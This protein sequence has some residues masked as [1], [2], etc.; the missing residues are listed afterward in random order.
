MTHRIVTT[1][2]SAL[3]VLASFVA[4]SAELGPCRPLGGD[5]MFCGSGDGAM[6]TFYKTTSPSGRLAFGWRLT[7]RPPTVVPEEND[8]NL[9]NIVA[10]IGDGAILAKSHGS[11]W[12]L[13]SKIAKEYAFTAW[14]TDSRLMIKLE[15]RFGFASAE[16]FAFAED[17]TAIGPVELVNVIKPAVLAKMQQIK[18]SEN[19]SLVFS[20]HP[21]MT[22]DNQGLMRAAVHAEEIKDAMNG[23][24]YEMTV[25][26]I[27]DKNTFKANIVSIVPYAGTSISIIVH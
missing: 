3:G 21:A 7:D 17:D 6:R 4:A 9:E 20:S 13:G 19:Y 12:D 2:L 23:P 27:R 24:V 5:T 11:Y 8:P 1:G 15:Q 10:R 18:D 26:V 22:I 25:Q 16:L 14:S